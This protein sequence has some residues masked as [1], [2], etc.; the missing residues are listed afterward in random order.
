[1]NSLARKL[2]TVLFI[3]GTQVVTAKM[4]LAGPAISYEFVDLNVGQQECYQMASTILR[5]QGLPPSQNLVRG[6][7]F[8][9]YAFGENLSF[10]VFIDCSRTTGQTTKAIVFVGGNDLNETLG[11]R[12]VLVDRLLR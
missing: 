11:L 7:S 5:E 10:T 3:A 12:Q 6:D 8:Y 1:M 9:V 2:T 4:A